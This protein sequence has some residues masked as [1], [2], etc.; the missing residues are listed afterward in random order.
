MAEDPLIQRLMA[1][2]LGELED[3]V[4]AL[5]RDLLALEKN[6]TTSAKNELFGTLFRT[7][8]SL[9]GAARSVRVNLVETAAHRLE[10]LFA[11][12]RD[13][14]MPVDAEFFALALPVVDAIGEAGR[15]LRTNQDLAG[16]PLESL[17]LRLATAAPSR[18]NM[19]TAEPAKNPVSAKT[20]AEPERW[21]GVVRVPAEK[22][23]SLL[24]HSGELLA[25]RHRVEARKDEAAALYDLL[26]EYRKNWR[27]VE[28]G[29]AAVLRSD[30]GSDSISTM[31]KETN[32]VVAIKRRVNQAIARND[33]TLHRFERELQRLVANLSADRRVFEQ[34][35]NPLDAEVRRTRMFPFAEACEGL[36]RMVR[37]LT[38]GDDKKAEVVIAGGDIEIDRS[39]LEGL[40]DPLLHLVRNAVDHGIESLAARHMAGKPDTGRIAVTAAVRGARVE[41][42]VADDGRGLD[43]A[44]VREQLRKREIPVP[45]N[46]RELI[47]HIFVPGFSTLSAVTRLSGRG[48][49]L[50][51]V[52]T[53]L[54]SMR[55]TVDVSFISGKGTRFTLSVPLTLTSLRAVLV[56]AGGQVFAADSLSVHKILRIGTQDI[57]LVEGREVILLDGLPVPVV[58][59]G[60]HLGLSARSAA[61]G[62]M[63]T[64]VLASGSRM[65]AFVV[66]DLRGEREIMVRTLG[67][68][69]RHIKY[70]TG[71][72]V[73]PDGHIALILN[74]ADLVTHVQTL[75][76]STGVAQSMAT[77]PRS[78]K[79][80]LLIV[81]DSMTVRTLEK[82]ILESAGYDVMVAVDGAEAWQLLLERGADL[83]I[84]DIEMP[85]MDGFS[86]TEAI[87]GSKRFREL[88]VILMTALE[89]ESDKARGM[90][91]GADAYRVK[92]AFDQTDL[93][94][95]IAQVL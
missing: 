91:V 45:D 7:A 27:R 78:V 75:P 66:D 87:R 65:A 88:P 76:L 73:L 49:G 37:D 28:Q 92:S 55:G 39:V 5:E 3:H 15:R 12:A 93:L 53:R 77:A 9:K 51:V 50:D 58:S 57:Q 60:K 24:V 64:I 68:R 62:V 48:V 23:D 30:S 71:G 20:A 19:R 46:D 47:D 52:K 21:S 69:L 42:T 14:R 16:S 22:L 25:I 33:E 1:T 13:G 41:V 80:R 59:L 18:G 2:F 43:L 38:A 70:V 36:E 6:L 72:M 32:S 84:T 10:E 85:H 8:H 34:T 31:K 67:S 40:K 89:N 74:A 86:L 4:R 90:E 63:P 26:G 17:A 83:V 61:G 44:A 29:V 79:K 35:A 11:A 56:G 81:D 54:N 95:T 94:A 82:S